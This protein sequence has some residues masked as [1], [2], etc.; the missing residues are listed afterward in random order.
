MSSVII[1]MT[2]GLAA[3]LPP[4]AYTLPHRKKKDPSEATIKRYMAGLLTIHD[5]RPTIPDSDIIAKP[6][7]CKHRLEIAVRNPSPPAARL[8]SASPGDASGRV[9][10]RMGRS[11]YDEPFSGS[12]TD[13]HFH[14]RGRLDA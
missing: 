8:T 3:D 2:L 6:G 1:R 12:L 13:F 4:V 10:P 14:D 11:A 5:S 9:F 7:R